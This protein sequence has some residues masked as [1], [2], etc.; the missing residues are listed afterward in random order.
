MILT[1]LH[2]RAMLQPRGSEATALDMSQLPPSD[3]QFSAVPVLPL[4]QCRVWRLHPADQRVL[5]LHT[6]DAG[7]PR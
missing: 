4:S 2:D 3:M 5:I 1:L 6:T 7:R